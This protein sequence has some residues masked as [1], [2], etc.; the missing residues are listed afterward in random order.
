M[1]EDDRNR[2][3]RGLTPPRNDAEQF[4]SG[5]LNQGAGAVNPY[6]D[7]FSPLYGFNPNNLPTST[8]EVTTLMEG[9]RQ[10]RESGEGIT[11]GLPGGAGFL[12]GADSQVSSSTATDPAAAPEMET[13]TPTR[14]PTP[15]TTS[16]ALPELNLAHPFGGL[17]LQ[18]YYERAD[19]GELTPGDIVDLE[20]RL[21]EWYK[22]AY[23][24]ITQGATLGPGGKPIGDV[25]F[26]AET[27]QFTALGESDMLELRRRYDAFASRIDEIKDRN[28]AAGVTNSPEE[29]NA[30]AQALSGEDGWWENTAILFENLSPA[31]SVNLINS[32][33]EMRAILNEQTRFDK[34][35][36]FR[37]AELGLRDRQLSLQERELDRRYYL[38]RRGME[39]Q[40]NRLGFEQEQFA[41]QR[42]QIAAARERSRYFAR[43]LFPVLKNLGASQEQLDMLLEMETEQILIFVEL[44]KDRYRSSMPFQPPL[45]IRRAMTPQLA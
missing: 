9:L 20:L 30:L 33:N 45:P 12:P 7:P 4:R 21:E 39:L 40:E 6:D 27:G 41:F 32:L 23:S 44:L 36:G 35:L 19:A 11:S 24:I 31:D 3:G 13:P 17:D 25:R 37:F 34:D 42:E 5:L 1:P 10:D 22:Q 38:D 18:P 8:G 26:D 43:S 28:A 16:T 2:L 29:A 15:T 14:T